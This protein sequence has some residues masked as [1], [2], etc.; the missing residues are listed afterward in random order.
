MVHFLSPPRHVVG[1]Q[2]CQV[3]F[4]DVHF[5]RWARDVLTVQFHLNSIA[6]R[7]TRN[8]TEFVICIPAIR[9][10]NIRDVI[11]GVSNQVNFVCRDILSLTDECF[12]YY[13]QAGN[14]YSSLDFSQ[15]FI[16]KLWLDRIR[17]IINYLPYLF[18]LS[19]NKSN[20]I[21]RNEFSKSVY[22]RLLLMSRSAF[23]RSSKCWFISLFTSSSVVALLSIK[24]CANFIVSFSCSLFSLNFNFLWFAISFLEARTDF[25]LSEWRFAVF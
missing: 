18:G 6:S 10:V 25:Q 13:R 8:K 15:S 19:S 16:E 5:N 3:P 11:C 21:S 22:S 14:F 7:N 23:K 20:F 24:V 17:L 9:G 4:S 12:C 1:T 2:P